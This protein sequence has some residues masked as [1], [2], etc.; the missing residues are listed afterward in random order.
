M[1]KANCYITR[2]S[3]SF[4]FAERSSHYLRYITEGMIEKLHR[5]LVD[6]GDMTSPQRAWETQQHVEC[7]IHSTRKGMTKLVADPAVTKEVN[8]ILHPHDRALLCCANYIVVL[9]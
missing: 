5:V 4:H 2:S 9:F 7:K 8:I 6:A 1:S 3:W